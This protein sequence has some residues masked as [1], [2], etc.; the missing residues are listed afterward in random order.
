MVLEISMHDIG[1]E[2]SRNDRA[3]IARL[4]LDS[5]LDVA[6]WAR[7]HRG[8]L[9]DSLHQYGAILFMGLG[10]PTIDTFERFARAICPSLHTGY[11]DLPPLPGTK[12]VY[13]ATPYPPDMTIGFHNEGSHTSTWPTRQMFFCIRAA[14]E[15]GANRLACGRRVLSRMHPDIRAEF[16]AKWLAYIRNFIPGLDVSWQSFFRTGD[17]QVVEQRCRDEGLEYEWYAGERLRIR[18]RGPAVIEHPITGES[19]WFNQIQLHHP[20]CLDPRTRAALTQLFPNRNDLPRHVTFGDGT[21]IP[22]EFIEH[23]GEVLRQESEA[24]TIGQGEVL[25]VDNVL[26]AHSRDPYVGAREVAVAMG[27]LSR[28]RSHRPWTDARHVL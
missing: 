13:A 22:D 6:E 2:V 16:Q 27:A 24:V 21:E 5:S 15:G 12:G 19:V 7:E 4:H 25:V 8:R 26:M 3:A 10:L 1:V 18:S 17:R 14:R 28:Y 9:D 20:S 23:I 11:G